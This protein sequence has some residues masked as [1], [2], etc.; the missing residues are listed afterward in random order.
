MILTIEEAGAL[1]ERP[2]IT[3][4]AFTLLRASRMTESAE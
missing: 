2:L 4:E 1:A 3:P